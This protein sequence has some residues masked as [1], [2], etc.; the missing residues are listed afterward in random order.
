MDNS[1]IIPILRGLVVFGPEIIGGAAGRRGMDAVLAGEHA[2]GGQ[3]HWWGCSDSGTLTTRY[4]RA[5]NSTNRAE[6]AN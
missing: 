4:R 3:F 2:D 1:D 5:I 6:R